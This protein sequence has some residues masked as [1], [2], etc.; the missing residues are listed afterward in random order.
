MVDAIVIVGVLGALAG[1][2]VLYAHRLWVEFRVQQRA[3]RLMAETAD[4][5]E[6]ERIP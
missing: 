2:V 3:A 1:A 5:L 6:H 4:A